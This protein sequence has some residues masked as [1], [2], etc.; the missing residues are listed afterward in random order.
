MNA[1]LATAV[2]IAAVYGCAAAL[3]VWAAAR[4]CRGIAPFDD[5]PAPGRPPSVALI[6]AGAGIGFTL[7]LRGFAWPWLALC[8]GLIASLSACWYSDVR[9]GI[10]PDLFT[11]APLV[12]IV[13]A[14]LLQRNPW[15]AVSATIV[16]LPF[17]VA[18]MA[19]RGVGMGWGDVKLVALGAATLGAQTSILWYI[20]ACLAAAA[21]ALLRGRRSAPIAFAPYLV[22]SIA[23]ALTTAPVA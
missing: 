12:L 23:L 22:T 5:G 6:A 1:T 2:P 17:A 19:S 11:L 14:A 16:L 18:A 9:C 15:P 21:V 8:A 20:G 3:G 13:A 7:A 4:L 10:V